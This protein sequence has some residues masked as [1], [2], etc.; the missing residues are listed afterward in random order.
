MEDKHAYP[1]DTADKVL[2]RMPD[3][4]R[5]RLKDAARTNNRTMN[6]EIIARL[7]ESFTGVAAKASLD[8]E[9]L[10]KDVAAI[11]ERIQ[12]HPLHIQTKKSGS[13]AVYGNH[14]WASTILFK[15]GIEAEQKHDHHVV[16]KKDAEE[17]RKLLEMS[18][19]FLISSSVEEDDV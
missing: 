14:Q 13:L 16:E 2:V 4:M 18:T 1:S 10:A 3:G 19:E 7:E 15:N 12:K 17:A 5:D 6:A 11:K 9:S 8:F